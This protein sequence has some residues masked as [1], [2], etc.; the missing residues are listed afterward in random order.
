[1]S[2][3]LAHREPGPWGAVQ[4]RILF[5]GTLG[6]PRLDHPEGIAVHPDGSIWCGGERGQIFRIEGD[7]SRID[8]VATTGGFCLGLAF[9]PTGEL[10]VCDLAR[11]AVLA[12]EVASGRVECFATAA[13]THRL[14]VPN[15]PAFDAQ[16]LLY[17]S[18]S[19]GEDP[20]PGMFRFAPDGSGELWY[21]KSLSFA[22]GLALSRDGRD[23]FVAETRR[24]AV[25]RIPIEPDGRPGAR[26]DVA[27]LP[28]I[29]PD[30][31]ALGEDGSLYVGCYEPSQVLRIGPT[32]NV[33]V[34]FADPTAHILCHPTN[35]AFR[36]ESLLTSNLGRW[37][38]TELRVNARGV[39]LPPR[40]E[41]Q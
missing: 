41:P 3:A 7:G 1:M 5:D 26:E 21:E 14:R 27:I 32:G 10:F 34:V 20:G 24:S 12:V 16:G 37:H 38:I 39:P 29:L 17:V 2:A 13:G 31:L 11:A 28:G 9:A 4:A 22:N 19:H 35:L 40:A 25:V 18:D 23:L 33:T 6:E 30:G 8:E 36:G 15:Y